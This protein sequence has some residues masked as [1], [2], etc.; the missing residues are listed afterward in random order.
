MMAYFV[1]HIFG[2]FAGARFQAD[3]ISK[4]SMSDNAIA[5]AAEHPDKTSTHAN[6][7]DCTVYSSLRMNSSAMSSRSFFLAFLSPA[8]RAPRLGKKPKLSF[9]S[10]RKMLSTNAIPPCSGVARAAA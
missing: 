8:F 6:L 7:S 10:P 2:K 3:A 4:T 5:Y 1:G 9:F